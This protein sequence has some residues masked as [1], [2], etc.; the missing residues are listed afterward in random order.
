MSENGKILYFEAPSI[1]S[2]YEESAGDTVSPREVLDEL[3][4]SMKDCG[5][6]PITQLAGYLTTE[7]PT[8]LPECNCARNL[9]RHA[10]RDDLLRTLLECYIHQNGEDS[11]L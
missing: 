3:I 1:P 5:Q 9:A 4:Q 11:A 7:D 6:D 2:D 8:Y 10:G